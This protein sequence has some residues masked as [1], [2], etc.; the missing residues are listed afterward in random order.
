MDDELYR[1]VFKSPIGNILIEGTNKVISSI[2]F[3]DKKDEIRQS[4]TPLLK[5]CA[6]QLQEY[7]T[8]KRKKFSLPVQQTGT[9]FQQRV[10]SELIEIPFGHLDSYE[11]I[12]IKIKDKKLVRAIGN[13][14]GRN[15]ISIIV[16]CHRVIGKGGDMTGYGGGLWR[17]QWLIEHEQYYLLN[18]NQ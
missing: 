1:L 8:G 6:N 13:A 11:E 5:I 16:P 3:Y 18:F 14:V 17:K 9:D 7:F 2:N 15:N 4:P 10:W 12:A